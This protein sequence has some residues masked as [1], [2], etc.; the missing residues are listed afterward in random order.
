MRPILDHPFP[1]G[2]P[3]EWA[4]E[5]GQDKYGVFESFEIGGVVQRMRWIE[6]G[7][8]SMGSPENEKGRWEQELQHEVEISRGYWIADTPCTQALWRVVMGDNPSHFK[9]DEQR[10]VE[11][12]SWEDCQRFLAKLGGMPPFRSPGQSG[13]VAFRLPTEAEWER[14]CRGGTTG[15]TWDGE[16]ELDA[17][18]KSKVLERIGWY[19]GN[20]GRETHRVAEMLPNPFGLYDM[21]GNVY[22]WCADWMSDHTPG[23]AVDP[24]G[25]E[26]GRSRV[27]RGG[28]WSY[29]ARNCRAAYRF[30]LVPGGADDSVGFRLVRGRAPRE[31]AEPQKKGAEPPA[32]V[33][34]QRSEE[35]PR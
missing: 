25:P 28:S 21:L 4:V 34:R 20:S 30:W 27:L 26:E 33:K 11:Q 7:R 3:D 19:W 18:D 5:W 6:P 14:A 9:G 16:L 15:A 1:D 29:D 31:W 24:C 35:K 8:F 13:E 10:P 2:L 17:E 23:L 22:E 12:V 32:P